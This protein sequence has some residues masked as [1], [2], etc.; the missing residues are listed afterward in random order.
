[1]F[2]LAPIL[3]RSARRRAASSSQSS[4]EFGSSPTTELMRPGRKVLFVELFG[5]R[6]EEFFELFVELVG[7]THFE[8]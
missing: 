1:M 5:E 6:F 4:A 7:E 8:E 3:M 2:A